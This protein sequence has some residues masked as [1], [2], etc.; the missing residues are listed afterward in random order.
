MAARARQDAERRAHYGDAARRDRR[1]VQQ[2]VRRAPTALIEGDTQTG[3][4]LAL[5]SDLLPE[6][7]GPGAAE[8]LVADIE[9]RGGHLST[10]FVG[11]G[12]PAAGAGRRRARDLAYRLLRSTDFPSWGYSIEQGATT[13]WERWDGWTDEHGF[14]DAGMNSFN[15]Y[16]L[17]SV[18]DWL[19]ESV[20]GIRP[21]AP[22]YERV[23]IAPQP[24]ELEWARATYRSVRG[25]IASAGAATET[26]SCS[27]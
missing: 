2:R 21:T 3:Y 20:A 15:H 25:E 9:R 7:R 6:A 4:L 24:G 22:G 8:R 16:A 18:G 10:G 1:R 27:R 17:G 23:L 26:R 19:Y 12:A 13:I 5:H 11:V 14:Q